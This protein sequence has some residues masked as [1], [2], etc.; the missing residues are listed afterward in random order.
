[1]AIY[2]RINVH[3][4]VHTHVAIAYIYV[5]DIHM[6]TLIK[7]CMHI[8]L[9][10]YFLIITSNLFI[11]D[12]KSKISVEFYFYLTFHGHYGRCW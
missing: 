3:R 9:E 11:R 8:K 12:G 5:I 7:V 4:Y 10:H 2:K 6:Y 1:M